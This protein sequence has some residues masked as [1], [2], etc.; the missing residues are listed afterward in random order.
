MVLSNRS[1]QAYDVLEYSHDTLARLEWLKD[2]LAAPCPPDTSAASYARALKL[3]R[4]LQRR[5]HGLLVHKRVF[6]LAAFYADIDALVGVLRTLTDAGVRLT[7][8]FER[9]TTLPDISTLEYAEELEY[10]RKLAW[11]RVRNPL[12]CEVQQARNAA[13]LRLLK[14]LKL[15]PRTRPFEAMW[16]ARKDVRS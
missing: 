11:R 8:S 15:P 16:E 3:A 10:W 9:P 13:F 5:L 7:L 14:R 2:E 4:S 1:S 6:P 12:I